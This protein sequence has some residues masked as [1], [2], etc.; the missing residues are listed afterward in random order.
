MAE[1][2]L[3]L[4]NRQGLFLTGITNVGSFDEAEIILDTLQGPLVLK[5]EDMHITQLNLEEGKVSIHSK[6]ITSLEYKPPHQ[7]FKGKSRSVL[8]RLLK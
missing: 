8:G 1:H 6:K 5:G 2:S 4:T 3:T 7:G